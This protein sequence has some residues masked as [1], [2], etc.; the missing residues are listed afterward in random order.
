MEFTDPREA[1]KREAK[2]L[3]DKGVD[4]IIVLSHCGLEVD[5]LVLSVL[6]YELYVV[7]LLILDKHRLCL[8]QN[9]LDK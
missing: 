5:K 3:N 1:M 8:F 7:I 9:I 4:I 2:E 6:S